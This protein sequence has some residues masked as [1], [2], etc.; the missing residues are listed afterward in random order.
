[1]GIHPPTDPSDLFLPPNGTSG[2]I[3]SQ[4]RINHQQIGDIFGG[5]R[6]DQATRYEPRHVGNDNASWRGRHTKDQK[7]TLHANIQ[8]EMEILCEAVHRR[9]EKFERHQ[10]SFTEVSVQYYNSI[11][12]I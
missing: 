1:M 7:D 6:F 10:Y 4:S 12:V 8:K 11:N 2:D 3:F 5:L 9:M